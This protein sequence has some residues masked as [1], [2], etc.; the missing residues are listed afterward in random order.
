MKP[1]ILCCIAVL[2]LWQPVYAQQITDVQTSCSTASQGVAGNFIISYSI[3]EMPLV[4]SWRSNGLLIT[5]GVLQPFT[6]LADTVFECFSHTEVK[7]YPNPSPGIFSLELSIVKKGGI[8]IQLT[9]ALGCRVQGDAFDYTGFIQKNYD[10]SK[11]PGGTYYLL[12]FFTETGAVKPKKCV[13]SIQK[14]K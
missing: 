11:L 14:I 9:D 10:I 6:F 12:L 13:Y 2:Y 7:L 3:G 4:Q 8:V 1:I 5:Q